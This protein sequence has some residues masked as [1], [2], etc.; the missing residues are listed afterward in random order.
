MLLLANEGTSVFYRQQPLTVINDCY[1][2]QRRED[3]RD[4]SVGVWQTENN[5]VAC[6]MKR[7]N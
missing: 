3:R 6:Q 1:D 7:C 5:H 4:E 2:E